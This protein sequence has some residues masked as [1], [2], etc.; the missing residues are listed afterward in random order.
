MGTT[1]KVKTA[2]AAVLA[3]ALALAGTAA[4]EMPRNAA[5]PEITGPNVTG[6]ALVGHNGTWLYDNGTGCGPECSYSFEWQRCGSVGCALIGGARDRVYRLR[7]VDLGS[8]IRLV[9]TTT[10]YDCG[11]GNYAAGT[12]ECR[13]VN[14]ASESDATRAIVR[15]VVR[16]D[17][18]VRSARLVIETIESIPRRPGPGRPF[19]LRI[20]VTD[21]FG[22][23]V[24]GARVSAGGRVASTNRGG[25]AVVRVSPG[26][27]VVVA[28]ATGVSRP[29]TK[30]VFRPPF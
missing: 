19:T 18:L 7:R 28:V 29:V 12:Q 11:A 9:V 8:Q 21:A 22:R 25:V 26:R 17:A 27:R 5:R 20:T 1:T 10:K 4:A 2:T 13:F 3:A 16:A 6:Y 23:H 14:R 15:G 30:R 24:G